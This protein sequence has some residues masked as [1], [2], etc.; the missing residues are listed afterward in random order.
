MRIEMHDNHHER[1]NT[2]EPNSKK[3]N[4][5]NFEKARSQE[6]IIRELE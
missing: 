3:K 5:S 6:I 2:V 1:E 4:N